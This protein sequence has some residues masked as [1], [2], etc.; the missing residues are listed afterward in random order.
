VLDAILQFVLCFASAGTA[1]RFWRLGLHSKYP[2]FFVYL[3]LRTPFVLVPYILNTRS[4]AYLSFWLIAEPTFTLIYI[5]I[6]FELYRLVLANYRGLH[7]LGRWA[8]YLIG[9]IS[10]LVSGLL[11][12][13]HTPPRL[14]KLNSVLAFERG[15]DTALVIFLI[16]MILFI[17]RY[18]I[19]L[20]R[21]VR[22]YAF[23]YPIFFLS[24]IFG[25]L[26]FQ[27]FGLRFADSV[28]S[29]MLVLNVGCTLAF[30]LLLNS[31]GEKI[32]SSQVTVSDKHAQALLKQL[33]ALNTTLLRVSKR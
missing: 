3:V 9:S 28:N 20:S 33:D 2:F 25:A 13:P 6:V 19:R 8:M 17:S 21:N 24:N 29:A 5:F 12:L 7:T 22:V 31:A 30:L 18:P 1:I 10:V 27:L 14:K 15:V 16:L 26:M 11:L 4:P 32:P 23:V